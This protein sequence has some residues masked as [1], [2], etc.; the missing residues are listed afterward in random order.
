MSDKNDTF[1]GDLKVN[2]TMRHASRSEM[3]NNQSN[4]TVEEQIRKDNPG[5]QELWDQY[6]TMLKLCTPAKKSSTGETPTD[7]LLQLIADRKARNAVGIH[8]EA[9]MIKPCSE[10]GMPDKPPSEGNTMTME[11]LKGLLNK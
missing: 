11:K 5:L 10:I 8:I 2:R 4:M 7:I 1:F 9:D 6:Q 3:F